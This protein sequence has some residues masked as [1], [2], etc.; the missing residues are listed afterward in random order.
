MSFFPTAYSR[1]IGACGGTKLFLPFLVQGGIEKGNG[2]DPGN[3]R[4]ELLRCSDGNKIA[5][6]FSPKRTNKVSVGR[7]ILE[8]R[9]ICI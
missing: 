9:D 7:T 8:E 2:C 6:L 3:A 4:A 1:D 5:P